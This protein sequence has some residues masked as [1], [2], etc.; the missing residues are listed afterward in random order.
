[1]PFLY[2]LTTAGFSIKAVKC[3]FCKPETTF[4]GHIVPD[5]TVRPD[6]ERIEAILRYQASK[7]QTVAKIPGSTQL[8]PAVYCKLCI[9]RKAS[10]CAIVLRK[11][12]DGPP[13]YKK[14]LNTKI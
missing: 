5:K 12:G 1:M 4:R 14:R 3:R 7:N 2:K 6:K 8:P 9:V 13:S 10:T 11:Y